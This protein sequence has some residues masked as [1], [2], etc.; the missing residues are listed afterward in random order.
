M[1][2]PDAGL[3]H[4]GFPEVEAVQIARHREPCLA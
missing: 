2:L 1:Q 4:G 3:I